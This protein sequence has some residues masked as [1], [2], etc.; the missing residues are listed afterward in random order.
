V[1]VE[2]DEQHVVVRYSGSIEAERAASFEVAAKKG[3]VGGY[4]DDTALKGPLWALPAAH[5]AYHQVCV[6]RNGMT[7]PKKSVLSGRWYGEE[8]GETEA[9][10]RRSIDE[11]TTGQG[12][13]DGANASSHVEQLWDTL[14]PSSF[15]SNVYSMTT[16]TV[17]T[18][19]V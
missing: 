14:L 2:L 5:A 7:A 12:G 6:K 3:G 9:A 18:N 15:V 4:L 13:C 10:E 11:Q 1:E 16:I 19:Y 17:C 8:V